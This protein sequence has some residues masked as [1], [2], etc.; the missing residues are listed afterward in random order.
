MT[1]SSGLVFFFVQNTNSEFELWKADGT[2]AGTTLVKNLTQNL[3]IGRPR[4]LIDVN[5]TLFFTT[6]VSKSP[7]Q[8]WEGAVWKSD[9]TESGTVRITSATVSLQDMS[10]AAGPELLALNGTVF[11]RGFSVE[12]GMELWR[13]DGTELGTR[14]VKDILPGDWSGYP[15][16]FTALDDVLYFVTANGAT[17]EELW[18]SD[19]TEEGTILVS[20]FPPSLNGSV[21]E[22][23][24]AV[25][26]S[27]LFFAAS[28]GTGRGIELFRY[29]PKQTTSVSTGPTM[30][31]SALSVRGR[32]VYLSLGHTGAARVSIYDAIGREVITLHSGAVVEG[33]EW[34]TP[35]NLAS[36][37]YFVRAVGETFALTRSVIVAR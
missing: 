20:D 11:F 18:R 33:G 5:G 2:E 6:Y 23:P 35:Q 9:G 3:G 12:S 36:G 4:S 13:T 21:M 25:N 28:D 32:M 16:A 14:M 22:K 26:G 30:E 15:A 7:G 24:V 27:T 34:A 19:G 29:D 37:V 31:T 1:L 17:G 10:S 8:Q